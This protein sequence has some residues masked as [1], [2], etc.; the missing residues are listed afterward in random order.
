MLAEE[1]L[2]FAEPFAAQRDKLIAKFAQAK[3]VINAIDARPLTERMVLAVKPQVLPSVCQSLR[4]QNGSPLFISIAAGYSLAQLESMLESSRVIRVM[5]NT[6]AQ[7]GFGAAG[8]SAGSAATEDDISFVEKLMSSVGLSVRVPDSLMH[9]VTGLSGSGPAYVY[10]MIDALSDGGVAQGLPRE[11]S[12]KLA[13]QT[14]LGAAKMVLETGMHPGQLR[15]QV[16]SSRWHH[17]RGPASLGT[18][19][20]AFSLHRSHR[21]RHRA[22]ARTWPKLTFVFCLWLQMTSELRFEQGTLTLNGWAPAAVEKVFGRSLWSW[23][24]R[25]QAWRAPAIAYPT[26]IEALTNKSVGTANVVEQWQTVNWAHVNL[27]EMRAEQSQAVDSWMKTRRGLIIMPTGTGKTE[28]ALRLM[29]DTRCSTL[30]VAPIRDLMYQWHR[31]I[32]R[33]LDYDAGIIGDNTFNV[34]AVSVTTYDSACIHMPQLGNRFKLLIF[35]ECHHLPGMMRSDAARM[36]IAPWRLGLSA[37]PERTDGRHTLFG[38]LIGPEVFRLGIDEVRGK[39]LA[40]YTVVRIPVHLTQDEQD[41]YEALGREIRQYM[42]EA[43]ELNPTYR[44][45]MSARTRVMI[46]ARVARWKPIALN[47][48]LKIELKRNFASSRICFGCIWARR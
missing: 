3:I 29:A 45:R 27:P 39:S 42:Q 5:P 48:R 37:T 16:T 19:S 23:D 11:L 21:C 20:H 25:S 17:H 2:I 41:R 34:K 18:L 47:K 31:R 24:M 46:W 30:V 32:L 10:A 36:S 33:A 8:I 14:V 35:D 1:D 4:C 6:P 40:E 7:V 44:G 22:L 26:I 12:L 43:R 38:E 15:D 28:V 13:A 9:A